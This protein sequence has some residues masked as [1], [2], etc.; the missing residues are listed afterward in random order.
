MVELLIQ[1][2]EPQTQASPFERGSRYV[3]RVG[4]REGLTRL[5]PEY[6]PRQ[7]FRNLRWTGLEETSIV[8]VN[9]PRALLLFAL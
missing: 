9:T 4:K 3:V 6:Y 8:Q 1:T 2:E 5:S 7:I